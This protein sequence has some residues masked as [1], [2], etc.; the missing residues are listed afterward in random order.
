[1]LNANMLMVDPPAVFVE[2]AAV[3]FMLFMQNLILLVAFAVVF[4]V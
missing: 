3:I 4:I 1:M 2:D